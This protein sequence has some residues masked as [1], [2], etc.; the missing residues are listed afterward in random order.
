MTA[1]HRHCL[2]SG[3]R[4]ARGLAVVIDVFRAFST[5]AY[6]FDRGASEV[7]L[8]GSVEDAFALRRRL[9][10]ALVMG[11]V[12]GRRVAGFDFG[13][14][15]SAIARADLRGRR[16]IQR[17]SAGT[18]GVLAAEHAEEIVLGSFVCAGAIVRHVQARKPAVVSLVAMGVGAT[19][20]APED[21][22]C[23]DLLEA[24][25]RGVPLDE[26]ALLAR[27]ESGKAGER[28]EEDSEDFPRADVSHCL[29]LDAFDFV[30]TVER[31]DG[32]VV[33][34]RKSPEVG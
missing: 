19:R 9:P 21:E 15:T 13:N 8:V 7:V 3:A 12:D 25:L 27:L 6:A 34:T 31:R 30:L 24:R 33:A 20:P 2:L 11:E 18:Q 1:I 28:F 10:D 26:S 32:L 16:L 23:G 17:T 29:R 4:E 5:A 22:A 14:S